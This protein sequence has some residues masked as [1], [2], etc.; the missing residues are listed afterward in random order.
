MTISVLSTISMDRHVLV[1]AGS[2]DD[3]HSRVLL[4]RLTNGSIPSNEVIGY[5][6]DRGACITA[7][8][9][10]QECGEDHL[11]V[12]TGVCHITRTPTVCVH[13]DHNSS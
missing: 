10:H 9:I 5:S 13:D 4:S 7:A 12:I 3:L 11:R 2:N 1:I 8:T 6:H